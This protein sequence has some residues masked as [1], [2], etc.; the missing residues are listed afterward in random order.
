LIGTKLRGAGVAAKAR[1]ES[2]TKA[3]L[4]ASAAPAVSPDGSFRDRNS[5][6]RARPSA[7][8]SR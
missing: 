6:A 4:R 8:S 2:A 1:A 7:W 3:K 5:V